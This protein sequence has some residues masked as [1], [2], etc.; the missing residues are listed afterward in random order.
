MKLGKLSLV[1]VMALGTSAFAIDNVK[2]AGDVKVIY[3]TSDVEMTPA[4]DATVDS[5]MFDSGSGAVL[6]VSP[7]NGAS[8]G[9]I[10]G[11]LGITADLL[12][13][14]SAG[15]EV[16]IYTTLGLENN[17]LNDNMVNARSGTTGFT[18]EFGDRA[19]DTANMS[20]LWL[21][22][23]AGKTTVKAGRMELDTPLIFTEKWNIAYNT[24]EG[25]VAVNNDIPDTTLIGAWV[26]K[27]NGHGAY[28]A[29]TNN[30]SQTEQEGGFLLA[31]SPGR[32]VDMNSFN[33]FGAYNQRNGAYAV[34]AINKSIPNTT[35]QAWY[36]NVVQAAESIWLQ[37]D[38]KVDIVSVG[39]QYATVDPKLDAATQLADGLND[40]KIWAVKGAVDVA[41]VN[42]YAAYSSADKDGALGFANISTG[43]K[44]KIYTGTDSIYFDGVVTAPGVDTYKIGASGAISGIKLAAAYVNCEDKYSK[45][46]DGFNATASTNVGQLGLAAIY[47][48]VNNGASD[49]VTPGTAGSPFYKGR[50]IDTFRLVASLKF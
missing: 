12:K 5:G 17:L 26:G 44:T 38:A 31:G 19:K 30:S 32:T 43:D 37:A 27:H 48:Q 49:T 16:Q 42:L 34:G 25:V 39:A 14:V 4:E 36:Y 21:A 18:N 35:V 15:A 10:S 8:A 9:G 23:T 2:V 1:A 7:Y 47:E 11:R 40:S 50:D 22:T 29:D 3:Q 33:S 46:V 28:S 6:G 20:Q 24:F 45:T 41:G 13:S